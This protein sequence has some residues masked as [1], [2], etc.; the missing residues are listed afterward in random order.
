MKNQRHV[1]NYEDVSSSTLLF[2]LP[3]LTS[4]TNDIWVCFFVR[5][6]R[7]DG[8]RDL[9]TR[10]LAVTITRLARTGLNHAAD[11]HPTFFSSQSL[12]FA[13]MHKI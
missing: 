10:A 12:N 3:S 2:T 4:F 11:M 7:T 9:L 13:R 6:S 8:T 1:G 5:L